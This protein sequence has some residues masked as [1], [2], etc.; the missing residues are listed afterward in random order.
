MRSG[1][2]KENNLYL[3]TA[4]NSC[5]LKYLNWPGIFHNIVKYYYLLAIVFEITLINLIKYLL[6]SCIP[7]L[8]S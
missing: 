6:L 1:N 3:G 7:E 8:K 2:Y 4:E 5:N